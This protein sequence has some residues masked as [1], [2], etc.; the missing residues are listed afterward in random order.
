MVN[1]KSMK[2]EKLCEKTNNYK[3]LLRILTLASLSHLNKETK[4]Y[5]QVNQDLNAR[6]S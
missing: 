2:T 6:I 1:Q 4:F 3:E 5:L